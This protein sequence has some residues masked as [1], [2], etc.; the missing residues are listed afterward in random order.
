M[1][2]AG[3]SNRTQHA[4]KDA[5]WCPAGQPGGQARQQRGSVGRSVGPRDCRLLLT[6]SL[7]PPGSP[8]GQCPPQC[9]PWGWPH[10]GGTPP[11][12]PPLL[13][14]VP[15]P[16]MLSNGFNFMY[17]FFHSLTHLPIHSLTPSL[18]HLFVHSYVRSF[19]RSFVCPSLHRCRERQRNP[20]QCF[21]QLAGLIIYRRRQASNLKVM[22]TVWLLQMNCT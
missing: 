12:C 10:E 11:S 3:H 17:S 16:A 7:H 2:Q 4:A 22:K 1:G 15:L 18:T 20:S 14:P 9:W 8:M 19:V 5:Y 21:S 6:C 13:P